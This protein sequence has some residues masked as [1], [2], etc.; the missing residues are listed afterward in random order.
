[1]TD[2]K[3]SNSCPIC[4]SEKTRFRFESWDYTHGYPGTF[5]IWQCKNCGHMY[6]EG[7][8]TPEM[9]TEMYSNYYPRSQYGEQYEPYTEHTGFLAWLDGKK[10][11][12]HLW[13]PQNVRILDIGCG[14]CEALGYHKARGCE[15]WGCE[16]DENVRK[17]AERLGVNVNIGLF[18]PDNYEKDYF[19][20]VTMSHVLE[21]SIDPI[22]MLKQVHKVLKPN[23]KLVI[24]MPYPYCIESF[25]FGR[26]W[27]GWH[28]PFH[29][30]LFS[31]KSTR[32]SLE[33][34][35]FRYEFSKSSTPSIRL[36]DQ[37]AVLFVHGGQGKPMR[38]RVF[39]WAHHQSFGN[40]LER[41]WYVR[42]FRFLEKARAFALP[43]RFADALGIGMNQIYV[44][45]KYS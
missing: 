38:F 43:V 4:T 2:L 7:N 44:A 14:G 45:T 32:L 16:A 18:N 17:I 29:P 24:G 26:Y 25:L 37:W 5:P 39:S 20:Y 28:T 1:M 3:I 15:V 9:L 30:N 6:L 31:K 22:E 10:A 11:G 27:I 42:L 19:D 40:E 13:V 23:G 41:L 33:K 21:H 8:F 12:C 35:G 36:L 34:A